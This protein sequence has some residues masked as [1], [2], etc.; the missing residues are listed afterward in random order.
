M[1]EKRQGMTKR[2]LSKLVR[3]AGGPEA[4][5]P[6]LGVLPSTVKRWLKKGAPKTK[7]PLIEPAAL[8]AHW[9]NVL[10]KGEKPER[11]G[12][13]KPPR[14]TMRDLKRLLMREGTASG[15]AKALGLS[16][17]T[18]RAAVTKNRLTP[19]VKE[20]LAEYRLA[21]LVDADSRRESELAFLD[22]VQSSLNEDAETARELRDLVLESKRKD[23]EI[24][25]HHRPYD[26]S[27]HIMMLPIFGHID[28]PEY[29]E[30]CKTTKKDPA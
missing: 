9:D 30:F 20:R 1:L 17:S 5:A 11:I 13:P 12:V 2:E 8:K 7:E 25:Q 6:H 3:L 27:D 10:P 28:V 4:I 16:P 21:R 15:A 14:A 26:T 18:I 23:K 19:L 24:K 22:I 29:R